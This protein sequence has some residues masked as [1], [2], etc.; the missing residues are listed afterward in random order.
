MIRGAFAVSLVAIVYIGG[1]AVVNAHSTGESFEREINGF[2]IDIGYD[3]AIIR[4]GELQRFDFELL[5]SDADQ[6]P[7]EYTHVWVRILED[8]K[9]LLATGIHRQRVGPTTLLYT[10]SAAGTYLL[11]VSY[12][13]AAGEIA[14]AEFPVVVKNSQNNGVSY[15]TIG[16]IG[17][18]FLGAVLIYIFKP[19]RRVPQMD[20]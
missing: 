12:R 2:V 7:R 8:K 18:I 11:S 3:P 5:A 16:A 10:F 15:N 14:A 17:V 13:D 4:T 19:W 20:R 1:A 9:T 6:T